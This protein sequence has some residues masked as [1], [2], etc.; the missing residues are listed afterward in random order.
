MYLLRY[1]KGSYI[2]EHKDPIK[3]ES[4]DADGWP[5]RKHYRLNVVLR[6]A[7]AGGEFVCERAIFRTR[8]ITLFRPDK[9]VHG[10][11]RIL[12]GTR[13]VLSLGVGI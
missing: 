6:H 1:P 4:A 3:V 11:T 7:R 5:Q 2:D 10:V 12:R 13:Y 9:V 8:R